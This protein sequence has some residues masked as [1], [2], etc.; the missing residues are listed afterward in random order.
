MRI[1]NIQGYNNRYSQNEPSFGLKFRKK[2]IKEFLNEAIWEDDDDKSIYPKLYTMLKYFEEIPGDVAYIEYVTKKEGSQYHTIVRTKKEMQDII[3]NG[4]NLGVRI[5]AYTDDFDPKRKI[6]YGW[7]YN[8]GSVIKALEKATVTDEDK[9]WNTLK[10]PERI[11]EQEWWKNRHV[12]SEDIKKLA[13][14]A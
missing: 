5:Y 10:M 7:N 12:T 3:E 13:I 11:F 6:E 1:S 8:N 2:D 4:K 14:D 9:H